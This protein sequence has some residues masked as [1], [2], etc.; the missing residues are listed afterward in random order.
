VFLERGRALV[1][2][3]SRNVYLFLLAIFWCQAH[4]TSSISWP[5][6]INDNFRQKQPSHTCFTDFRVLV[7]FIETFVLFSDHC[8]KIWKRTLSSEIGIVVSIYSCLLVIGRQIC[9]SEIGIVVCMFLCLLGIGRQIC[10]SA[11]GIVVCIFLCLLGIGRKN[12]PSAI[13]IVV[14]IFLC[15][16]GIGRQICPSAIGIRIGIGIIS[17]VFFCNK[18]KKFSTWQCLIT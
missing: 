8:R 16:I 17:C 1:C 14:C 10:P 6:K 7:R 9:P 18:L 15:I 3:H 11:I 2:T 12:C 4:L 13:G 5:K